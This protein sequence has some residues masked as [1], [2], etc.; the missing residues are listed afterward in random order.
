MFIYKPQEDTYVTLRLISRLKEKFNIC[1]DVGAGSCALSDALTRLCRH[2]VAI[3]INPYSCSACRGRHDVLCSHGLSAIARA[4][5]V[6][7]NP[8]YLP[9]EEPP[10]DW[11]TL[12]I[13]D[14]GLIN[15]IL[16][17]TYAYRPRMLILT[18]STLG[19]SDVIEEAVSALGRIVDKEI[20][21]YFFEDIMSI[22]V[23]PLRPAS[24]SS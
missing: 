14:Y 2:I 22:A 7:S 10:T 23:E 6:V 1:I 24:G 8:P 11:E 3:D 16:R 13:Y 17:W 5:L 21:H 18:F 20:A 19:R 9:P 12:A 4:D 15:H